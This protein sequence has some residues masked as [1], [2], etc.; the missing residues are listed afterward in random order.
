[1]GKRRTRGARRRAKR[2][3]LV[4]TVPNAARRTTAVAPP[5]T[6]D[7]FAPRTYEHELP[8]PRRFD[9]RKIRTRASDTL[10]GVRIVTTSFLD[11][12]APDAMARRTG[13][14]TRTLLVAMCLFYGAVVAML[15][16]RVQNDFG[17]VNALSLSAIAFLPFGI[18][19]AFRYPLV[20]PFGAY[21][22]LLPFDSLLTLSS[23][24]TVT[25]LVAIATGGALLARIVLLQDVR[26][27]ARAWYAWLAYVLYMALSLVWSA[28]TTTGMLVLQQ[29]VQL[30]LMLTILAIYPL[31]E[32]EFRG[33]L[34][35]VVTS[36]VAAALYGIHLYQA[37]SVSVYENRLTLT[38]PSGL[39]LDPN[40]YATS[41]VLPIAVAFAGAFYT[42]SLLL[43]VTCAVSVL[44]MMSGILVS[45]SRG[46]FIAIAMV[47]AYFVIRSKHRL[48]VGAVVVASLGLTLLFPSVFTR[49]ANDPSAA[50]SGSGRTYIWQT[51]LHDLAGHWLFGG[52]AGSFQELYDN[53]LLASSQPIFQGWSRP[54]H[55]IVV[56]TITEYGVIG[57]AL[58]FGAWW[59]MFRQMRH[60]GPTSRLY[61]A[62]IASEGALIGL[63]SQAFFIDIFL[64]KY[65]WLAYALPLM[66]VNLAARV[67]LRE[68]FVA[69]L[70]ESRRAA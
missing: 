9:F 12:S 62:R 58:V 68:A 46:G 31:R 43:R 21:V 54:S 44:V 3:R 49:F 70:A 10:I 6:V 28:D 41:F 38:T 30:F 59:T 50:G 23:G 25:R 13:G 32:L 24:G 8:R 40:Y 22:L 1:M 65:Y 45:G 36:G 57:L 42:R 33:A 15:L 66:I 63:F 53:A 69:R 20:F 16:L 55:S 60:I 26:R 7:V 11:R 27:P 37:G 34:A 4:G 67:D 35:F 47:F 5:P 2:A 52:G 17:D 14:R 18:F 19:L 56:G 61:G 48:Q 39:V 51:G 29:V 64:I